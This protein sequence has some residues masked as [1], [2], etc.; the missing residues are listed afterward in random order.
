MQRTAFLAV[1]SR[2]IES[3]H[4]EVCVLFQAAGDICAPLVR[5]DLQHSRTICQILNV[6]LDVDVRQ[7]LH[8]VRPDVQLFEL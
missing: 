4:A 5:V 7:L 2:G 3:I 1:C 6:A 8:D